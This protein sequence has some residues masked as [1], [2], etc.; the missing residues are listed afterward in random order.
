MRRFSRVLIP[1]VVLL[2]LVG[3]LAAVKFKQISSLIHLGE[4]M[5][6]AG[7]PPETVSTAVATREPW[8][9]TMTAVGSVT[10]AKGVALSNDAAGVVTRLHFD[11]GATVK[12]GQVLVELD[13]SVEQSQLASATSRLEL[14]TATAKRSKVLA[15]KGALTAAEL[16]KDESAAKTAATEIDTLRAQIAR[17][18]VRAPFAGKLGIRQ[19]N[20]GQYLQ[21]GTQLTVLESA[22]GLHVDF[23]LPQQ[24]LGD[25]KVGM[26][27]RVT[28]AG[29][30]K[31]ADGQLSAIDPSIDAAT[32]TI[33]LQATVPNLKEE[34]RSGMFVN[35]TVVLPER[36]AQLVVP[37]TAIVRAAYGNSVFVVQPGAAG[38]PQTVRQQFVKLGDARGDFVAIVDG[39]KEGET[40]VRAGAFKLRNGS[41][42]LVNNDVGVA[43]QQDPHPENR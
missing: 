22:G 20:V 33:K 4:E 26:P 27:V 19:V 16:E 31:S 1:V 12:S 10:A 15:D 42:I 38:E 18:I 21:P 39:V 9:G 37:L 29:N 5:E 32:R 28:I 3:G 43:P 25:L 14:A 6:K 36:E 17:K 41:K 23:A 34:L 13:S 2:V 8:E 11:S 24:R 7:A 40:V 30:D 35:V